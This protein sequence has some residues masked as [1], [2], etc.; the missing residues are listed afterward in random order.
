MRVIVVETDPTLRDSVTTAFST[1]GHTVTPV[2]SV[3]EAVRWIESGVVDL[4]VADLTNATAA[5]S[6][7]VRS[8]HSRRTPVPLVVTTVP[9][10]SLTAELLRSGTADV[11]AYPFS[12]DALDETIEKAQTHHLL[13]GDLLKVQP[14]LTEHIEFVI[15]SRVEYLDGILNHLSER[16]VKMR[17]IEPDSI[18]VIVALDEAIV[19]AIKHGNGYDPAKQVRIVAEITRGAARFE[20]TDE[21]EGFR[22][23]DVPDP[24]APENLLR[25]SGR[26]ILLIRATMDEVAYNDRGNSL[27]MVKRAAAADAR[28]RDR[29]R[30]VAGA[31]SNESQPL[32]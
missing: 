14:F 18:D 7:L 4:V 29:N 2:D 19:N 11:L 8:I 15:P 6:Q 24:C 23:Q 1:R 32:N 3:A 20:V 13:H 21:G 28:A 10:D 31:E 12:D 26:G 27:R 25:T 17:V 30:P 5:D 9:T 16:L 22:M